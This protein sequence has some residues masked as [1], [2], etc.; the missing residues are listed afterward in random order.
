MAPMLPNNDEWPDVPEDYNEFVVDLTKFHEQRGY[1]SL[2][3]FTI[4]CW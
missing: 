1:N 4:R 3:I 2:G